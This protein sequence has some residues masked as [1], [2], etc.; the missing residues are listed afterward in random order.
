MDICGALRDLLPFVQFIKR[1]KHPWR[2]VTFST[3]AC[4]FTKS[5][6]PPWMFSSFLNCAHSTKSRN[7]P[8]IASVKCQ[9]NNVLNLISGYF[10][11]VFLNSKYMSLN[12]AN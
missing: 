1:E 11:I 12:L 3:V 8:H 5:N 7:A 10:L 2:S 6:I 9:K 4:N